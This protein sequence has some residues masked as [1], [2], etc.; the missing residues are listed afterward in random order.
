MGSG[1]PRGSD[2]GTSV[3]IAQLHNI[4]F[5][6]IYGLLGLFPIVLPY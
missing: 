5:P 4:T 2:L 1:G 6:N 3:V